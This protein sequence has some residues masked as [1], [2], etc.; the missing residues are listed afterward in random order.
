MPFNIA[1]AHMG[2]PIVAPGVMPQFIQFRVNG[3]DL[4]GPDATVLDFIGDWVECVRG[5]GLDADKLTVSFA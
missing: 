3:V 1:P 2:L 4:G 5:T